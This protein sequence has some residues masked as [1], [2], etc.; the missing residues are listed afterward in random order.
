MAADIINKIIDSRFFRGNRIL[1]F[2]LLG[3]VGIALIVGIISIAGYFFHFSTLWIEQW[4]CVPSSLMEALVRPYTLLTYS[5]LHFSLPHLIFNMLWLYW[6]GVAASG[7]FERHSMIW[8]YIVS[9]MMGGVAYLLSASLINHTGDNYLAGASAAVMGVITF[10][11]CMIPNERMMLFIFGEVEIKWL[12]IM[13]IAITLLCGI[14]TSAQEQAAH[15]GGIAGGVIWWTVTK[16]RRVKFDVKKSME[17]FQSRISDEE[18]LDQ[19]LDKI[20]ISGYAS[21]SKKERIE[22]N[23]ISARLPE[24]A[25]K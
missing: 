23:H 8:P 21:L 16:R 17:A 19:L 12:V 15:I 5:F 20:R 25:R 6:F 13:S 18:R 4:F 3:N 7:L 9:G 2:L 22:L 11:G 14:G 1:A 10:V 24:N